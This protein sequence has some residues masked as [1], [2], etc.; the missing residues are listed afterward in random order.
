MCVFLMFDAAPEL[1]W[2][3]GDRISSRDSLLTRGFAWKKCQKQGG[4]RDTH[5][6]THGRLVIS[7]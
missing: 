1:S 2:C 6:V 3:Q 5:I 4:T 7:N